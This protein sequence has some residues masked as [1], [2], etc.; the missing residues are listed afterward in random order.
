MQKL[1]LSG[2]ILLFSM[3]MLAQ[4]PAY[5]ASWKSLDNRPIP[6]WFE[7]AKLGIFI[8]WGPY[9][10]PA[11]SP[12]GSYSEWYQFWLENETVM[13]NGDFT[14]QEVPEF[15]KKTYGEE[16]TYYDFGEMFKADLFDADEWAGLIEQSG[17]KYVVVTSKHHDGFCL[18]PSKEANDRG[19]PWNSVDV[20]AKKDLLGELTTAMHKSDI[21]MGMYFSLYEWFHPWWLNDRERFVDDHFHPQFKDLV[22]RYKPDLLWGDGE[23]S[24]SSDKWKTEALIAWLYNESSVKDKV[25]INDRWGQDTRH[26][27]GGYFTTEYK[28][29][30][31][32]DKPWEECRG[33][34]FS[35]G[36]N[37]NEDIE[38][39]NS[40]QTL[41]LMLCDLVAQGGNLLLDIGPDGRG[42]IPVI[43]Q[44]RLVQ[45]GEWMDVNGD[46]IYGTRRWKFPVQWTEGDRNCKRDDQHYVGGDYIL[47]QTISP[48]SP[49]CAVKEVF[50][51]YKDGNLFAITPK[52]PGDNLVLKNITAGKNT[53]VR[54]LDSGEEL[55][56]ESD[57]GNIIIRMPDYNPNTIKTNLAYA[58]QITD[59]RAY[60]KNPKIKVTYPG[61]GEKTEVII[62]ANDN[63]TI[64][65]TLDGSTPD[66]D[67][68]VYKKPIFLKKT[69]TLSCVAFEDDKHPSDMVSQKI[70][71]YYQVKSLEL[72]HQPSE[73]Y[74]ANGVVSL[75]DMKKG[76]LKIG[77]GNWLGFEGEDAEMIIDFGK[78][79]EI[80]EIIV[81]CLQAQKSWVFA[82]ENIE[83]FISENGN[84]FQNIGAYS[85]PEAT[86]K[87][88]NMRMDIS[89]NFDNTEGRYLKISIKNIGQCPE[90]H[91]GAG[92]T[93]WLFVDEIA[94]K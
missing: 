48:I 12:K 60:A 80:N 30:A 55:Q 52:W 90:W 47:E 71:V 91:K 84:Q 51:T 44:E 88:E 11:W 32:F 63:A 93:C 31:D 81:G 53:T 37:R 69:S 29:D 27:H 36:Y 79:I 72:T 58:F 4:E 75:M 87:G 9:S 64:Y 46:A 76:S 17:A 5:D 74:R 3:N 16:S 65:Y 73:R 61:F 45:L 77:D 20:G 25:I 83:Y 59:I 49:E 56:W 42:Q 21:K 89:Q 15:Q 92:G 38:D 10:V 94:I 86:S 28:S 35:F 34:G 26:K 78:S 40:A 68:K 67:S 14:G 7:D 6:G 24:M 54:F 39:Y 57:N 66:K 22:E 2:I 50:F 19:F 13:G 18:W 33:M 82:P 85:N 70:N 23:W 62:E 41:V 8:H 1:I 43:M